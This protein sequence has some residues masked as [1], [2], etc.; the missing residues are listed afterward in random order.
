MGLPSAT[1]ELLAP[2]L[3]PRALVTL[4]ELLPAVTTPPVKPS[5]VPTAESAR[6]LLDEAKEHL[7]NGQ[8]ATALLKAKKA[9]GLDPKSME[10]QRLL[11]LSHAALGELA[12]AAGPLETVAQTAGDD[13]RVQMLLG[14]IAESAGRLAD[15]TVLYRRALACSNTAEEIVLTCQCHLALAEALAQQGYIT[16]SLEC[17]ARVTADLDSHGGQLAGSSALRLLIEAPETL[18]VRRGQL[19]ML[20][21]RNAEAAEVLDAAY[22]QNKASPSAATLLMKV[23]VASKQFDKAEAFMLEVLRGAMLPRRAAEMI[24]ALYRGM[25]DSD[26]PNRLLRAYMTY[27]PNPPAQVLLPI[28]Q[29]AYQMG[30]MDQAIAMLADHFQGSDEPKAVAL[31]LAGWL[32]ADGGGNEA[33]AVLADL[34]VRMP[35]SGDAVAGQIARTPT[36]ALSVP[37]AIEI[38]ESAQADVSDRKSA[39]HYLAGLVAQREGR[40]ELAD[41]QWN[42]ALKA[43]PKFLPA[44]EAL[45]KSLI[46]RRQSEG[47]IDLAKA[48]RD[49]GGL[50]WSD[51]L[52]G[53]RLLETGQ[54]GEA[55]EHLQRAVKEN[56]SCVPARRLLGL[57]CLHANKLVPA[58]RFLAEA[59]KD[60][61]DRSAEV[62]VGLYLQQY[63]RLR[64]SAATL[65]QGWLGKAGSTV[66]SL[67]AVDIDNVT[68]L[69]LAAT[70]QQASG[71]YLTAKKTM[72]RLLTL[73]PDDAEVRLV[74]V[75]VEGRGCL[76]R[77]VM[78]RRRFERA[79]NDLQHV[80]TIDP[81][82]LEALSLLASVQAAR[83]R[84][85]DS[86]AVL[87]KLRTLKSGDVE[88]VFRYAVALRKSGRSQAAADV[89]A[90]IAAKS[91]TLHHRLL[92]VTA[93]TE[94]GRF[95]QAV[96]VL[97]KWIAE[98]AETSRPYQ[99]ALAHVYAK[100]GNAE[101]ADA[102]LAQLN[103][104]LSPDTEP[105][106]LMLLAAKM[107]VAALTKR[108]ALLEGQAASW[109][110]SMPPAIWLKRAEADEFLP[111]LMAEVSI[112]YDR[113]PTPLDRIA[114]VR[115]GTPVEL[116][117]GLLWRAGRLDR[118][119]KFSL[120]Q[121][122]R[123]TDMGGEH[124][125]LA[126]VLRVSLIR[127]LCLADRP[128]RAR[129]LYERFLA[130]DGENFDLLMISQM[131]Y[132][133]ANTR[134]NAK[135]TQLLQHALTLRP[136][137]EN[138]NNNLGYHWADRGIRLDE[139][140]LLIRKALLVAN[141]P[142]VQD[143]LGWVNY[144][145]GEFNTALRFLLP[146][147]GSDQGDNAV[148][149]DH[150]GD[151]YW[152]LGQKDE[153]IAM[154]TQAADLAE[155]DEACQGHMLDQDTRR[156][157]RQAMKKIQAVRR[158]HIPPAAPLGEGPGPN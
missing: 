130:D 30:Q 101:K 8:A 14:Q 86:A 93:L 75:R 80:L 142:N 40:T 128:A 153:A 132:T 97:T 149:Y 98:R 141:R 95:D 111:M 56:P 38:A 145:K 110:D 138:A 117:S 43:N 148:M 26:G 144:K 49:A 102:V 88:I 107:E 125:K 158:G 146:A 99:L 55:V 134:D 74:N 32:F 37:L 154:W 2:P 104:G 147:L 6:T 92:Y 25:A 89:L 120:G 126:G 51:Y 112:R 13:I 84:Y 133:A 155:V 129:R 18:L 11:G 29:V 66:Q 137:D 127:Q 108:Y 100:A 1:V 59:V 140:E 28:A 23:L 156:V 71:H 64:D 44:Y 122:R 81:D 105:D 96:D 7:A 22:R 65:A 91:D 47:L 67:L 52:L 106:K 58:E 62:L 116:A 39:L 15:S 12:K 9:S 33:L 136:N 50:G 31:Q 54:I 4:A 16:A 3:S 157:A 82:N 115:A 21:R 69:R 77:E 48:A 34:L 17:L 83:H 24:Q 72:G 10:V 20:L 85:A 53:W 131:V 150:V 27:Q 79:Q 135:I 119:E 36:K 60:G 70:I 113:R 90:G 123:L 35:S 121:I 68:G 124:A 94:I 78:G 151:T 139:S 42:Q 143:S 57:A 46:K 63:L 73:A 109:L 41:Q 5:D 87:D 19:L 114:V 45:A 152:R 76:A 118:A 103:A 61:D